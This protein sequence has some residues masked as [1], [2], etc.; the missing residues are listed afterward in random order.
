MNK[1]FNIVGIVLIMFIIF[2]VIIG[3]LCFLWIV[4]DCEEINYGQCC[5]VFIVVEFC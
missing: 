2:V 4:D 3:V 5:I 1:V